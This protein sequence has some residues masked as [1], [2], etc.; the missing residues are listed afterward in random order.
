LQ[1]L[2]LIH[3]KQGELLVN[4]KVSYSNT[5]DQAEYAD[6]SLVA[7]S[8]LVRRYKAPAP[9]SIWKKHLKQLMPDHKTDFP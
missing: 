4:S 2:Q 6:I 9:K 3:S 5:E 1:L 8:R 7:F